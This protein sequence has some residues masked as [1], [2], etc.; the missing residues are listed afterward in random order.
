MSPPPPL[1]FPPPEVKDLSAFIAA[2]APMPSAL[3]T[4]AGAQK[5]WS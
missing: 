5:D 4:S 3:D 1:E 2:A